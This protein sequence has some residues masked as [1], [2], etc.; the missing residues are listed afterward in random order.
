MRSYL[1]ELKQQREERSGSNIQMLALKHT[2]LRA[3][4][5]LE[6]LKPVDQQT[7]GKAVTHS[8]QEEGTQHAMRSILKETASLDRGEEGGK[9]TERV[10]FKCCRKH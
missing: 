7:T 6:L 5:R 1:S 2:V 10:C 3:V 4:W 8:S 9:G